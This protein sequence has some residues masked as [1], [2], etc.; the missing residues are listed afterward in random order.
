MGRPVVL[1]DVGTFVLEF[2]GVPLSLSV[3]GQSL[4]VIAPASVASVEV[5]PKPRSDPSSVDSKIP[6][7]GSSWPVN[8]CSEF[9]TSVT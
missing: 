6:A 4:A 2:C 7:F 1:A 9:F 8:I 3:V 5:D